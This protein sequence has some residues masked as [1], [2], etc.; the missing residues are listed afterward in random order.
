[1][2]KDIKNPV[3]VKKT[4]TVEL[5]KKSSADVAKKYPAAKRRHQ[6]YNQETAKPKKDEAISGSLATNQEAC[7]KCQE[8]PVAR[9]INFIGKIK[10]AIIKFFKRK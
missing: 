4:V 8:A 9:K 5:E 2:N 7:E 6:H 1:M 10:R 3:V